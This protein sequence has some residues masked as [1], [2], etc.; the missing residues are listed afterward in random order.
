[1]RIIKTKKF[2]KW[3]DQCALDDEAL[4]RAAKEIAMEIYEANY[5]GGVIKKR[6]A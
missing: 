5:G 6:I 3:A 4:N 2:A 1:M